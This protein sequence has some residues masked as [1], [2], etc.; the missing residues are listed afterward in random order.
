[1]AFATSNVVRDGGGSFAVMR[2]SWTGT[3]GDSAGTVT[4]NGNVISADFWDNNSV[5]PGQVIP[6]RMSTTSGVWTVTVPYGQ[7]VTSGTFRIEFK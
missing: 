7:T 2:G 5:T 4:G 3:V 6:V 1:M